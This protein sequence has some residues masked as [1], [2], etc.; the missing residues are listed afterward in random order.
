[1][2]SYENFVNEINT[3]SNGKN[4]EALWKTAPAIE[5]EAKKVRNVALKTW[6]AAQD[7]AEKAGTRAAQLATEKAFKT[8]EDAEEALEKAHTVALDAEEAWEDFY[9]FNQKIKKM[10]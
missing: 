7:A 10:S 9:Y 2:K 8:W 1:M 3:A 5:K 4:L 6:A